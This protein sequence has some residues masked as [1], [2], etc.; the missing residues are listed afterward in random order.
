MALAELVKRVVEQDLTQQLDWL[1]L[2]TDLPTTKWIAENE[3]T[4]VE[5]EQGTTQIRLGA[6]AQWLNYPGQR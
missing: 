4:V 6:S 2:T 3:Q 1:A 5:Q